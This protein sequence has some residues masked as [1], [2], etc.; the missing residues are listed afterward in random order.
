MDLSK[1]GQWSEKFLSSGCCVLPGHFVSQSG[2]TKNRSSLLFA[3][4]LGRN[5]MNFLPTHGASSTSSSLIHSLNSFIL[6][7]FI[8]LW[9]NPTLSVGFLMLLKS[10]KIHHQPP[11]FAAFSC[12][13]ASH[14]ILLFCM[15]HGE[16]TVIILTCTASLTHCPVSQMNP[17]L[18]AF[19]SNFNFFITPHA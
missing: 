1:T 12:L 7:S 14:R 5:H 10:P 17:F 3:A 9:Q 6:L 16:Y 19:L 18:V 13:I 4:P 11:W 8:P 2:D 15:S